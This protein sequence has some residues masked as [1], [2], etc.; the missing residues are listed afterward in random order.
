MLPD[1]RRARRQMG[2]IGDQG[3]AEQRHLAA[4]VLLGVVVVFGG[5]P[6]CA[7]PLVAECGTAPPRSPCE[8]P[9]PVTARMTSGPVMY[10]C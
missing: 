3:V 1:P 6:E 10:M 4:Q 8:I 7:T 2:Q 5:V 9:S